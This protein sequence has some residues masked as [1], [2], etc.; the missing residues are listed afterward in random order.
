MAQIEG[1]SPLVAVIAI[2]VVALVLRL[3]VVWQV[4]PLPLSRTPQLDSAEYLNWARRIADQGFAWPS[5]PGHAPGYPFF[6]GGLL[7]LFNGS[8]MAVRICQAVLAS[9]ACVLTA[10]IAAR[11]LTPGAFLPAGLLQAAYGPLIY[12]DT[13]LLPESLLVFLLVWSLDLATSA[14]RSGKRWLAAGVVL[15]AA[16]IVRSAALVLV[17]AYV[18]VLMIKREQRARPLR[19]ATAFV[20]GI[21]V[22]VGPVVVQN[23][24]NSGSPVVEAYGGMNFYLGNRPSGDGAA[25]ARIGGEWDQLDGEAGRTSP[26]RDGQDAYYLGRTISEIGQRPLGYL[27]VVATKLLWTVQAIELRDTHSFEF[28]RQASPLLRWLPAFGLIAALTAAGVYAAPRR[29]A[30][31]LVAY[32]VAFGLTMLFLVVGL[33]YRMP[34][35]PVLI[36]FAGAGLA[37]IVESVRARNWRALAAPVGLALV[38][39][40]VTHVRSD[41]ASLNV[42]EEWAFTGLSLLQENDLDGAE[43]AYRTAASLDPESSFAWDGLGFVLQLK[44]SPQAAVD[45]LAKAVA[46]NP[47]NATAWLHLGLVRERLP[48]L[49]GALAAYRTAIAI[50]PE[51]TDMIA[52]LGGALLLAGATDDAEPLLRKAE[53]R[54]DP[55]ATLAL[56]TLAMQRRDGK[57][58][59]LYAQRAV[60][61]GPSARSWSL[62][63]QALLVNGML[64]QSERAVTEAE[65]AGLSAAEVTRLRGILAQSRER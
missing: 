35:V 43:A 26:A 63:A 29:R 27:R 58:G 3:I 1:S 8:L 4:G 64:D 37:A 34:I 5:F 28:F 18:I 57:N 60:Q 24:R 62:F 17:P 40:G 49:P 22:M 42:A 6:A 14:E 36:A 23:S 51:R 65:R 2:F 12:L 50:T 32:L 10:R 48:D 39:L 53:A 55:I 33:R 44:G 38:I 31:W 11:T 13:A 19:L 25:R 61:R 41:A 16:C 59:L 46:I 20:A 30:A 56:A 21:L 7:A 54:Q 9:I 47:A 15:G 45:A 52:A